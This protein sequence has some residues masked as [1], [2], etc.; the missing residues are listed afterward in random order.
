MH[1]LDNGQR[2]AVPPAHLFGPDADVTG[3]SADSRRIEPG[4]LFAALPGS[5]VDGRGFIPDA[6]RH[7]AIAVLAETGTTLPTTDRTISLVTD[8]CAPRRFARMA[9]QF[10]AG[11]PKCIAAVTGTNGKTSVAAFTRQMWRMADAAAA[12]LGTLGLD[13][14]DASQARL[15]SGMTT[16][17]TV[18]LHQ[19]LARLVDDGVEHLVLEA[20]SHGLAQH[21]LDGVRV[22][23]GAFTNLTHDH[24]DYHGD[25]AAY[26]QAKARLF[27]DIVVAGGS[28]VLNRESPE[29]T[30][31]VAVARG[32]R[33]T[34]LDYG[35]GQGE[36]S[37]DRM[38]AT[39]DGW[40]LRLTL[41]GESGEAHLPLWGRFQV[42]N[43]LAAAGIGLASGLSTAQV[44]DTLGRL[45]GAPGRMETIGTTVAGGLLVVDY[46][47]TPDALE[48]TLQ[49]MRPHIEGR[50]A[51]VFGCGGDR[52]SAKRPIMG[53]IAADN[54]DQVYV[55]D[56][57][58]RHENAATIRQKIM[59]HAPGACEI[60]DRRQAIQQA[61]QQLVAGDGL[62]IA[63]KGHETGQ[64]IGDTALPFDDRA[65]ARDLTTGSDEPNHD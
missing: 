1:D 11:Q 13:C 46:A 6:L 15:T 42:L 8:D 60:A 65:I 17:D 33:L 51:V 16:P 62:L 27:S 10:Y 44:L 38:T 59:L 32:R 5:R 52:D 3:L 18:E 45:R 47:H 54:A 22:S 19:V 41:C 50:L 7:G 30:H 36:I 58:P 26:R 25:M 12:S 9:S 28:V 55:T 21:R 40:H 63:G 24:L 64:I 43:A 14:D 53:K 29:H 34:I 49:A 23:I 37:C 35:F 56:D 61:A 2:P 20:S 57:N 31:L 4:M 48:A 39:A